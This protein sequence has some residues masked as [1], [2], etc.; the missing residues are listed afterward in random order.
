MKDSK[1][2][3][4]DLVRLLECYRKDSSRPPKVFQL[5]VSRKDSESGPT[6]NYFL[7]D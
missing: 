2:K 4:Q 7:K 5:Q 6:S 3:V 1:V